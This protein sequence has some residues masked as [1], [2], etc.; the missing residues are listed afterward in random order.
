MINDKSRDHEAAIRHYE[1]IIKVSLIDTARI[2]T[3]HY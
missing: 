3:A 1:R 2:R